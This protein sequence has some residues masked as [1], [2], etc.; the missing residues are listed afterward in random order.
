[1]T[2]PLHLLIILILL[3]TITRAQTNVSG[4]ITSKT[5]WTKANSPYILTGN[6]GVPSAYTLTIEPGVT[7]QRSDDYQILINGA[8]QVD[9]TSADTIF[10]V[11]G[12]ALNANSKFFIEFKKSNLD[13]SRLSYLSFQSN[14]GKT[15]NIRVGD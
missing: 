6:V 3:S 8:V 9:G 13:N 5:T 2:K 1:M 7:V 11:N 12:S 15:N 14:Y 4:N 10:F